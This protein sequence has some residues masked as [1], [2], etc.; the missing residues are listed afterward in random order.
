MK[1]RRQMMSSSKEAANNHNDN[2]IK[3]KKKLPT[4]SI[5]VFQLQAPTTYHWLIK[6][7]ILLI[8]SSLWTKFCWR[9]IRN[10]QSIWLN[11]RVQMCVYLSVSW[12]KSYS[13]KTVIAE[14]H[15]D[16]SENGCKFKMH[17]IDSLILCTHYNQLFPRRE[18]DIYWRKVVPKSR[19]QV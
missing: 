3:R 14:A 8:A 17:F 10:V 6:Y 4:H 16:R 5:Q 9:S 11:C 12:C 13:I 7:P 15:N 2:Q 1:I 18:I 19:Y